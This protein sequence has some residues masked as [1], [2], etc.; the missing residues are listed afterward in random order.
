VTERQANLETPTPPPARVKLGRVDTLRGV[1]RAL[2]RITDAVLA[3]D[4]APRTGN[5]AIYGLQT[6]TRVLEAEVFEARL[7]RLED[8]AG[9]SEGKAPR[10][11]A[12]MVGHA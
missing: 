7:E 10:S 11:H 6:I 3:G 2:A 4:L 1:R 12:G 9:L 8:H 5:T